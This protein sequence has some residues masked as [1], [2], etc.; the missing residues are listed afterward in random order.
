MNRTNDVSQ[1]NIGKTGS[2]LNDST[3]FEA[4]FEDVDYISDNADQDNNKMDQVSLY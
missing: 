3:K 2:I 1:I 4:E